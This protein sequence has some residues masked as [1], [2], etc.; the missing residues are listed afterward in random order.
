MQRLDRRKILKRK[1]GI[2]ICVV[3]LLAGIMALAM[4]GGQ[5]SAGEQVRIMID[6]KEYGMYSLVNDRVIEV[7]NEYGINRIV[8]E[9]GYVH[10]EEADCPDGYCVA[11]KAIA[12]TNE[13]IVCLPHKLV[14]EI[15]GE[16][17]ENDI[18]SVT[19]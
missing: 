6:G 4:Y 16:T 13:T 1:D 12:R 5:G 3:L 19:Q 2:I 17:K 14:V 11:H 10:M 7:E 15:H 18:D 9:A 8:I